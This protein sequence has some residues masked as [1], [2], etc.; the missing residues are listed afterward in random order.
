M[1]FSNC[2]AVVCLLVLV[3]P[4]HASDDA[5]GVRFF[6][7]RIRPVLVEHCYG[8]HSAQAVEKKSLKGGL[9]LDT[10]AA[11]LAGG[12][13][14]AL[15][16]P[17]EPNKSLLMEALNHES[18]QMPPDKKLGENV[19]ADFRN[20][21]SMGAPDPRDGESV[22][23]MSKG[24]DIESGRRFW[25]FLPLSEHFVPAVEN[26]LWPRNDVDRHVL[27]RMQKAGLEPGRQAKRITL[28][29]RLYFGLW[30]LP[31]E[32][33]EVEAFLADE[34]SDAYERLVDSLLAG[35]HYGERWARHWLDLA[36]F[37]ESNGY[38]FDKDRPAAYHYRD[39][40]IKALN[41]DM[42]YSEFVRLQLAGDVIA[43]EDYMAQAATGFLAAGPFTSQQTQKERERSR[44]EQLD[45]I[46][47][48][49]GTSMLGLTLGCAR[50][51]DHKF[52]PIG[53]VDYY[54]FTSNFAEV[55]FQD[56][57]WDPDP[58][59]TKKKLE[60]FTTLHEPFIT[61][62]AIYEKEE[63]PGQFA[64]WESS[65]GEAPRA[66]RIGNWYHAGPFSA[67]DF[68]KAFNKK[69][70]PENKVE[71]DK[72]IDSLKWVERPEWKD[73]TVH[74]TLS[75]DNSANYLFRIIESSQKMPIDVSFG[76]DDGIKVFLNGKQLLAKPT[77]GGVKPDQ[78]LL[79]LN[80]NAGRNELLVKVV[81]GAGPS[82]FYFNSSGAQVPEDV[83]DILSLDSEQRNDSQK[84][85]LLKWFGPRDD[86]WSALDRAEK[87]HLAKK[88]QP[89][90]TPVFAAR[91]N[92][93]TYNF[94][95]D[96]RKVYFL[97]RGNSNAKKGLA[98]P[99]FPRVLTN[100]E[101]G[102]KQWLLDDSSAEK[103]EIRH[104]R[105]ALGDWMSDVDHGAG[106]LL[107]RVIVNRL[108]QHHFGRGL[109]NTP[110]DFGTQGAVPTHPELLDFLA[111]QLV[112]N[113]WRLKPVHKLIVMSAAYRQSSETNGDTVAKDPDNRLLARRSP[114]RMEAEVIRDTLL[115]VG[116]MLDKKMYG[117]GSLKESDS[118][119]SVYLKVKR[120]SLVPMMQLFDAPDA[121][122]SIGDRGVTTVPPQALAL[123]NSPLI[124]QIA[125]KMAQQ[126]S[127][128]A[129]TE[130]RQIVDAI[131][132]KT[133]SRPPSTSELDRMTS[134]LEG[135]EKS[136][137]NGDSAKVDAVSDFC[138]LMLCLN[139]F[140]Y[141]D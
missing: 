29:R 31:P 85:K 118:R 90:L 17:G 115:T 55:G 53:T 117:P 5:E 46:V 67:A 38:A 136:Y 138:Q 71:L 133:L 126:L 102:E 41:E 80:L 132:W 124:R 79:K 108:W 49:I 16:A 66:E 43:P 131:F 86:G 47:G 82:G 119:R 1:K 34:D 28:I 62:R 63:L 26:E 3:V 40:V 97:A 13:S 64:A 93:A 134:F 22:Q 14:G 101:L 37:A 120:G 83:Q 137:G 73:G 104:P 23:V 48:T 76:C 89:K 130:P 91:R 105:V 18:F 54:R 59:G 72:P 60:E 103:P 106:N 56:Y 116:D 141:V 96:T 112:S 111:Q 113:G 8:C 78:H 24:I 69:F 109:V 30:G 32:K 12:E 61:A 87:E 107:A 92:G 114:M 81:N 27:N 39:F 51:H 68:N 110:S 58:K 140:V 4:S 50:C 52:D 94:G 139:E 7:A 99:A 127:V 65:K 98:T 36:R 2:L 45:D 33:S 20:W 88:P 57:N 125:E 121:I 10:R 74:N 84:Q 44:Y 11:M 128:A 135:Q 15:F 122:Q 100:T 70:P 42:P 35:E 129:N 77:M 123:M 25:S 9:L 21:I 19:I 95:A 75:G 6:E